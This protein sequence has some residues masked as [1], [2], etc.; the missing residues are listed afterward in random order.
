MVGTIPH[1]VVR[2]MCEGGNMTIYAGIEGSPVKHIVGPFRDT[3]PCGLGVFGY[4][5]DHNQVALAPRRICWVCLA[6]HLGL[7]LSLWELRERWPNG[8]TKV[9]DDGDEIWKTDLL[10]SAELVLAEAEAVAADA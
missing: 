3:T 10:A 1:W 9:P 2:G 5:W 6:F 7:T 4:R 8:A